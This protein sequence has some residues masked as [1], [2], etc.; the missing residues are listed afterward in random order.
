MCSTH[1]KFS[2]VWIRWQIY[3]T[4]NS[5]IRFENLACQTAN[6]EV[7]CNG[8]VDADTLEKLFMTIPLQQRKLYIGE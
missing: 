6:L 7:L 3:V 1:R 4:L 2:S 8:N 5:R